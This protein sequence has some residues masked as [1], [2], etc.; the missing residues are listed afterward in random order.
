MN[1]CEHHNINCRQGR[2]CPE[3]R[4][5]YGYPEDA[6]YL[7]VREQFPPDSIQMYE[8]PGPSVDWQIIVIW[9][10]AVAALAAVL[11]MS[12]MAPAL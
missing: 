11:V 8:A 2:D 1:C 6:T 10:A 4:N 3:R 5:A 9:S 7:H 12:V